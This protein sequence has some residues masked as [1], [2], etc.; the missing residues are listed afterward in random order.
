MACSI[1]GT[2]EEIVRANFARSIISDALDLDPH[3]L[4]HRALVEQYW[5]E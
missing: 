1:S 3:E 5:S 2:G 4:L